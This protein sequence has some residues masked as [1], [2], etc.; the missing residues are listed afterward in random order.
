MSLM[1]YV[2]LDLSLMD[3]VIL[4]WLL[5]DCAVLYL[6]LMDC[7]I[8]GWLLMDCAVLESLLFVGRASQRRGGNR[9][10]LCY[11][12]LRRR[13]PFSLHLPNTVGVRCATGDVR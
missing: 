1:D 3:C 5:M 2:V 11:R 4:G 8:L 6:S 10:G 13:E 7:V 9:R 12:E